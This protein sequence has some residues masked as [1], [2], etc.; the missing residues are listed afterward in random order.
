MIARKEGFVDRQRIEHKGVRC[1]GILG[2]E[3]GVAMPTTNEQQMQQQAT[4][5]RTNGRSGG[6]G[7]GASRGAGRGG[8]RSRSAAGGGRGSGGRSG[9]ARPTREI[10][11]TWA[12][13]SVGDRKYALQIQKAKNGNPCLRIV[14][15][16]PQ[17]DGSF[18]KFDLTIWSE[19]FASLWETLDEVRAYIEAND[20][21]TPPGHHYD[22]TKRR[23]RRTR[24]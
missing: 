22:P 3:G 17:D 9:N 7:G 4:T 5:D 20:I 24:E 15:G 16:V 21:R 13:D 18:R 6:N 14:E 2:L 23:S 1:G 11:Q 10:V 12:F 8:S 19:D